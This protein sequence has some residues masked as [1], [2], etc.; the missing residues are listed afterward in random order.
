MKTKLEIKEELKPYLVQEIDR[1][2]D[3]YWKEYCKLTNR[4]TFNMQYIF[5]F[6]NNYGA[7]VIK[8]AG[9]Y[10]FEKDKFELAVI[11]WN[12]YTKDWSLCYDTS[13][14]DDV[15]PYLTSEEVMKILFKIKK[16]RKKRRKKENVES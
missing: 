13:I 1:S 6:D 8:N 12:E 11:L 4:D 15:I 14:T 5:K 9:S 2:E 10:G 3:L 16:L 7:S